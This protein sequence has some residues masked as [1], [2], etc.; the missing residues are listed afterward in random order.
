MES[1]NIHV[2]ATRVEIQYLRWSDPSNQ[3]LTKKCNENGLKFGWQARFH[4]HIIRNPE[5]FYRIR[6]YILMNPRRW[7]AV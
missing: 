1:Q 4:D 5:E 2:F 6:K 7:K 3:R